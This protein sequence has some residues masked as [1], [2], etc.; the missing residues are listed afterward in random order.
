MTVPPASPSSPSA[1]ATS[2]P[3]APSTSASAGP[4]TRPRRLR[5]LPARRRR[6]LPLRLASA[7]RGGEAGAAPAPVPF[8]GFTLAINVDQREQVDAA[9]AAARDAGATVL[10]EPVDR[11]W[12]GRSAYFADPEG[13]AWEIAWLPGA[14]ST[15]AA[16]LIWP[17]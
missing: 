12:G 15:S 1:P 9:L 8:K 4:R 14:S 17:F 2:P 11:D 13:N 3:C 16:R 10:A 7:R 6:A 5:R